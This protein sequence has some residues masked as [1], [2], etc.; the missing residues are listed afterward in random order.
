MTAVLNLKS[1]WVFYK[2]NNIDKAERIRLPHTWNAVDGQ[3]GGNDYYRGVCTY[4]R[5]LPDFN[6]SDDEEVYLEFCGVDQV[7]DVYINYEFAGHHEG[8][9]SR[10]YCNITS[11]LSKNEKNTLTVR[12]SNEKSDSVYP[13][14]ADF[15]FFGGIYRDV[16]LCIVHRSHFDFNAIGGGVKVTPRQQ[17][18]EWFVELA[19]YTVNAENCRL[20]WRIQDGKKEIAR[21][22][23]RADET[24]MIKIDEPVLWNGLQN[25]HLYE[26][27]AVLY[28]ECGRLCA[29]YT[30]RFGLRTFS[31]DPDKGFLLNGNIY[32]LRGVARHQDRKDK[33]YAIGRAEHEEDIQLIREIGANSVRLA[34]Y[35]HDEYFYRLCDEYGIVVWAEVPYITQELEKGEEN[36]L[37]QYRELIAQNYNHVCI[38]CWGM[39][40]EIT[41]RGVTDSIKETHAAM[42]AIKD[43]M[44]DTRPSTMAH[45]AMLPPNDP[46]VET[47]QICAYNLYFG[48]YVGDVSQYKGWFDEFHK[49]HP[50]V[51]IG[52]SEYGTDALPAY[53]SGTPE[54]GDYTESYQEYYHEKVAEQI[55]EMPYLWCSYVWNMFDFAADAR[56]EGGEAG[57]NHKGLVTY[58]RK[59]KKDAFYVYKARWSK[60]PFVH[61][62]GKRYAYRNEKETQI[63]VYSNLDEV[64]LYKDGELINRKSGKYLFVFD[65][66]LNGVHRFTARANGM[67]D[68]CLIG[69]AEKPLQE[70]C[71]RAG[72]E[73]ANWLDGAEDANGFLMSDKV[74]AIA[75]SSEG[76][77]FLE[78][79]FSDL[80]ARRKAMG[81]HVSEDGD[82]IRDMSNFSVEKLLNMVGGLLN[83]EE[84]KTLARQLNK[85]KKVK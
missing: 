5:L 46:F 67:E 58:D 29:D 54:V 12:V 8:G 3:D 19:P 72:K 39:S 49:T 68:E 38:C 47:A 73:V 51:C 81:A 69:Y 66:S 85:I 4:E 43:E 13:Q 2:G 16:N 77:L 74:G 11:L 65:T 15:T 50:K 70:Y 28:D 78:N 75:K 18:G 31:F 57:I 61:I 80:T 41:L 53:Q 55:D 83:E 48:W 71:C 27:S 14:V 32:P 42:Q 36:I 7:A 79:L 76:R 84:I 56:D 21:Q 62:A 17:N 44:D 33:G 22:S 23:G 25:P 37:N 45:I 24:V 6:W 59:T 40:N 64:E 30:D 1:D 34:H 82:P 60:E 20:E 9:Y 52:L 35:Q 10:F 26:V 63:R